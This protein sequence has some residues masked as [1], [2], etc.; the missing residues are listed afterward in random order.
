MPCQDQQPNLHLRLK[1]MVHR[2][3]WLDTALIVVALIA[4]GHG[5]IALIYS[6]LIVSG[7]YVPN[8]GAD[9]ITV[10]APGASGN[11]APLRTIRGAS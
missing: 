11:V 3:R 1:D 4:G 10:Y 2:G 8:A 6:T 5:A 9:S 7:L